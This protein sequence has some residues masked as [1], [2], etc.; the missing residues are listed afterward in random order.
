ML[1]PT[2]LDMIDKYITGKLTK[3]E[4]I[5]LDTKMRN[6]KFFKEVEQ[7]KKVVSGIQYAAIIENCAKAKRQ[8]NF[9]ENGGVFL[10]SGK[11][12]KGEDVVETLSLENDW[13]IAVIC[14]DYLCCDL[15][16]KKLITKFPQKF[17][18]L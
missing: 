3:T 13:S 14:A 5:M 15:L 16:I 12:S 2:E 18:I 10:R 8:V 11:N 17:R 6:S 9:L 7:I 1:T 4:R